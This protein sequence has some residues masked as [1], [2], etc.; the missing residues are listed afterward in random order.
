MGPTDGVSRNGYLPSDASNRGY[1]FE[2]WLSQCVRK[3]LSRR[4]ATYSGEHTLRQATHPRP[5]CGRRRLAY[6]GA[7]RFV[8]LCAS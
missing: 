8:L 4:S 1:N 3:I 7:F 5:K 6:T 2:L